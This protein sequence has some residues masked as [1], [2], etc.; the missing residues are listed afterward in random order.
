MLLSY[1]IFFSYVIAINVYSFILLK[2]QKDNE[3]LEPFRD[4]KLI[5]SSLLGGAIAVYAGMLFMKFRLNNIALMVLLPVFI[6]VH[7]YLSIMLFRYV[8]IVQ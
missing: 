6:A 3:G 5:I 1:I 4:S 7:I 2:S 8:L